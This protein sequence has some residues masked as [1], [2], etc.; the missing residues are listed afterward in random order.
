MDDGDATLPGEMDA[1]DLDGTGVAIVVAFTGAL[2]AAGGAVTVLLA[3]GGVER[4]GLGLL[5]LGLAVLGGAPVLWI[6]LRRGALTLPG[7]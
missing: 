1:T 3:G 6:A 5:A 2:L 7:I 4:L